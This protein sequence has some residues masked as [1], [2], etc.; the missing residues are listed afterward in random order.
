MQ[1]VFLEICHSING[2]DYRFQ[3]DPNSPIADVKE[4][5]FSCLKWVGQIE[6]SQMEKL[7]ESIGSIQEEKPEE[8]S[9]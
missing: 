1:K 7:K 6:D 2:K 9:E 3:C 5:L 4:Y 8:Q